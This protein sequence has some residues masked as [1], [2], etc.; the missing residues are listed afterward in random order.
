MDPVEFTWYPA[1]QPRVRLH[2]MYQQQSQITA[3]PRSTLTLAVDL[4]QLAIGLTSRDVGDVAHSH[5]GRSNISSHTLKAQCCNQSIDW[6]RDKYYGI[7]V[8]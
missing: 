7:V 1:A 8:L 6:V 4:A 5:S 2:N 3:P